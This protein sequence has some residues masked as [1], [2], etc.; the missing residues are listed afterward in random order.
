MSEIRFYVYRGGYVNKTPLQLQIFDGTNFNKYNINVFLKWSTGQ[1]REERHRNP[2]FQFQHM[3]SNTYI[4]KDAENVTYLQAVFFDIDTHTEEQESN[5]KLDTGAT[6]VDEA[7][8]KLLTSMKSDPYIFFATKSQSGTGLR[9]I[10]LI[11]NFDQNG[12]EITNA[13]TNELQRNHRYNSEKVA[14]YLIMN[15]GLKYHGSHWKFSATW[16]KDANY[17]DAAPLR[18]MVQNSFKCLAC[19]EMI[20]NNNP[21]FF[22]IKITPTTSFFQNSAK[23]TNITQQD[24]ENQRF[25]NRMMAESDGAFLSNAL[26]SYDIAY[27]MAIAG[28][29]EEQRK[30]WYGLYLKYYKKS[31]IQLNS[32]NDF[33]KF[34]QLKTKKRK[35][36]IDLQYRCEALGYTQNTSKNIFG[37]E[38]D[39]VITFKEWASECSTQIKQIINKHPKIIIDAEPSAGKTTLVRKLIADLYREKKGEKYSCYAAPKNIILDQ[40][41]QLIKEEY[42][43]LPLYRNYSGESN[44]IIG[45]D[46]KTLKNFIYLSSYPSLEKLLNQKIDILFIDEVQD[47]INYADLQG[48][49]QVEFP[50][51]VKQVFFSATPEVFMVGGAEKYY[52]VRLVKNAAT[53]QKIDVIPTN[54]IF[55]FGLEFIRRY[56]DKNILIYFNNKDK[57]VDLKTTLKTEGIEVGLINANTKGEQ[58]NL[59]LIIEQMLKDGIWIGT[60]LINAGINIKNENMDYVLMLTDQYKDIFKIKQFPER[61]R[62]KGRVQ[63]ILATTFNNPSVK[64]GKG[65]LEIK[66]TIDTKDPNYSQKL[67]DAREEYEKKKLEETLSSSVYKTVLPENIKKTLDTQYELIKKEQEKIAEYYNS[68]GDSSS[69]DTSLLNS[70]FIYIKERRVVINK[71]RIKNNVV[72]KQMKVITNHPVIYRLYLS[73]MFSIK[74]GKPQNYES[75]AVEKEKDIFMDYPEE[76]TVY[77]KHFQGLDGDFLIHF[78]YMNPH[79]ENIKRNLSKYTKLAKRYNLA[80]AY[81]IDWKKLIYSRKFDNIASGKI[82]ESFNTKA[83]P[84]II[85]KVQRQVY[86]DLLHLMYWDVKFEPITTEEIFDCLDSKSQDFF[87]KAEGDHIKALGVFIN[88]Y[89]KSND[90][91]WVRKQFR[92]K[93]GRDWKWEYKSKTSTSLGLDEKF[94]ASYNS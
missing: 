44:K 87:K 85:D 20:V 77:S 61:I 79:L 1:I 46:D 40:V 91:N 21:K 70:D 35:Y 26:I 24:K 33:D 74:W 80:K 67:K 57:S 73:K 90:I 56:K 41:Y 8:V 18:N 27:L 48:E 49:Q 29:D 82:M 15:Y 2:A 69:D 16:N 37:Y 10:V 39:Q 23:S 30:W 86:K 28:L 62:T 36:A 34:L 17:L 59:K 19:P 78:P 47:L 6:T 66:K 5:L 12:K 3:I 11:K 9:I 81:N 45:A 7:L 64:Y 22:I 55:Q 32:F 76:I 84:T 42:P 89:I 72:S 88:K 63:I 50:S 65:W 13:E 14:D 52:K 25:V 92:T 38:Y 53:K 83:T 93:E 54:N 71:N 60:D 31:T 4:P 94:E 68:Y 51:T 75:K 43:N 58:Q